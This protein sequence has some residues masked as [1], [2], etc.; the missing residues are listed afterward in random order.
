MLLGDRAL[1]QEAVKRFNRGEG[2]F[3]GTRAD[4]INVVRK[5]KFLA[6]SPLCS[7]LLRQLQQILVKLGDYGVSRGLAK[8]TK[9][10]SLPS[11]GQ[12][13]LRSGKMEPIWID[14]AEQ[15]RKFCAKNDGGP[16]TVDTESDHFHAYQAR[17]C[18][19]QVADGA[20]EAL[21]D[22]LVLDASELEP[23][24]ELLRDPS[25]VKILHAGRN[26]IR[27]LDRDYGIGLRNLFDTQI[28]ARFLGTEQNGLTWM[29]EELIGVDT[30]KK[31]IRFDWTTRPVP[32][33][34]RRYAV[35]DVRYLEELRERFTE[36]LKRE[37]WLEP[38][39]QQCAYVARSMEYEA[40]EFAPEDW[41]KIDG[42]DKLEGRG[43]AALKRLFVWRHELCAEQNQSA[44]TLFPNGALLRLAREGPTAAAE[45]DAVPGVP[46]RLADEHGES[47]A[48][49]VQAS[50]ADAL[51]PE[52]RLRQS[53]EPPPQAQ[54][55]RYHALR[56]WRNR[57][58]E[59]LSIPSEFIATN[60]TISKLAADPP[61]TVEEL[62]SFRAVLPWQA[63]RLGEKMVEVLRSAG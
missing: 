48:A 54:R 36:E 15:L 56:K 12:T 35:T 21:I 22:P 16:L 31:F 10:V 41:R 40:N 50:L 26:D 11:G 17:V 51:P 27:E 33:Q 7:P 34:A 2:W 29:L 28:A 52:K 59:D 18:L 49:V 58:A 45:V 62:A 25:I 38:C 53:S 3:S 13:Q 32:E 20:R 6:L 19:I 24:F 4:I 47:I 43:R 39:R 55:E 44:V 23:L 60:D 8:R 1:P 14:G 37:N 9:E 46:D 5:R 42:S 30:G 61:A 63:D 57:C